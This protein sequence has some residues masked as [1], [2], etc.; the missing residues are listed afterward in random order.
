MRKRILVIEDR[1]TC[2]ACSATYDLRCV[3]KRHGGH[4]VG[5]PPVYYG[6]N[7]RQILT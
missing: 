2:A 1:K 4:L 5:T 6:G 7:N 3:I